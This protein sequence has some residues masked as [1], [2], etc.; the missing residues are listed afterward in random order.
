VTLAH[1]MPLQREERASWR[2]LAGAATALLI[3]CIGWAPTA[4]GSNR[5]L[6]WA[7]NALLAGAALLLATGYAQLAGRGVAER[8]APGALPL[9]LLACVMVWIAAQALLPAPPALAHAAW[10][11]A[12]PLLEG[13]LSGR[14]SAN[15]RESLLGLV[16]LGTAAAVALSAL[17]LARDPARARLLLDA[18]VAAAALYALYGLWR[19]ALAP[20]KLLWFDTRPAA[21]LTGPFLSPSQAATWFGLAAVAALAMLIQHFRRVARPFAAS[22]LRVQIAG[23][24]GLLP[25]AL[26]ARLAALL[27]VV[28]ALLLT[29]SRAGIAATTAALA[30][31]FA[32]KITRQ[33]RRR[34]SR[35]LRPILLLA[36][37]LAVLLVAAFKIAGGRIAE[38]LLAD[39]LASG[40]RLDVYAMTLA[41]IS[42]HAWLG[43]GYGTFQDVFPLYRGSEAGAASFTWDKAHN[44][45]L[46]LV[47]GLGLPAAALLLSALVAAGM[48]AARGAVQRGRDAAYPATAAAASLLVGLHALVDFSLQVQA[49]TLAYA[50]LMGV[51]LAQAR[52][53]DAA[54]PGALRR[55]SE[56]AGDSGG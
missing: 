38:R 22:A 42:D 39:G 56:S 30:A 51:G 37:A 41:A 49:I 34:G 13:E 7:M 4:L 10:R 24:L 36:G 6:A 11:E 43:S 55:Q 20:D 45:Y 40:A 14:I 5:P 2:W 8:L 19:L 15:P 46:E 16:R 33:T 3:I 29:G 17:L 23:V 31:I 47:L 50:L 25:W 53:L 35:G 32:L 9:L 18:F 12:A 21:Y 26:G 48:L 54:K 52:R 27:L 44:D 28:S 1:T